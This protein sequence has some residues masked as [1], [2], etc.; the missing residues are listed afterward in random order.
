MANKSQ[1]DA[2]DIELDAAR[3]RGLR[4]RE[5]QPRATAA[6]YDTTSGRVVVDLTNGCTF[7]FP[8]HLAQGLRDADPKLIAEVEVEPYGFALHWETLDADLTI[9]GLLAGMFGSKTWMAEIGRTGGSRKSE[10]KTTA[11][12]ANGAK[13]GRPRKQQA[14]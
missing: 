2:L 10:A 9:A 1:R 6:Y 7:M 8:A 4:A 11:S 5:E 12:R 3:E 14:A 13:G